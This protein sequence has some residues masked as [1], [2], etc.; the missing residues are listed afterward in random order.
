VSGKPSPVNPAGTAA[1]GWPVWL[2]TAVY[3]IQRPLEFN[4]QNAERPSWYMTFGGRRANSGIKTRSKPSRKMPFACSRSL[5]SSE[6]AR[7][8]TASGISEP[9]RM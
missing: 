7:A 5:A 6:R 2:K 9:M 4:V 8:S 3:G 1:A